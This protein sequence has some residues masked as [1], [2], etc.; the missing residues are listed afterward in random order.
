MKKIIS[1][2]TADIT[3]S[4]IKNGQK[5]D[6]CS[7]P[8][9]QIEDSNGILVE[10]YNSSQIT[11]TGI[12]EYK[13]S[14]DTSNATDPMSI[15]NELVGI[16]DGSTVKFTSDNFPVD[17]YSLFVNDSYVSESE[18]Q[19]NS[20]TGELWFNTAPQN[21]FSIRLNYNVPS[22]NQNLSEGL[23]SDKW[24]VIFNENDLPEKISQQFEIVADDW[25]NYD[26][27]DNLDI[28][29]NIRTKVIPKN[30]INRMLFNISVTS[31]EV[32]NEI[33]FQSGTISIY[34]IR[35]NVFVEDANI[36]I[37]GNDIYYNF[38]AKY[39]VGKYYAVIKLSFVDEI[40]ASQKLWF[41]I[42]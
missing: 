23:Y 29:Y 6:P 36:E 10:L 4:I 3:I 9:V 21:G 35:D 11:K 27:L 42:V 37:N 13:V 22:V 25:N 38:D 31:E 15:T 18:Y 5:T 41:N 1:G 14:F 7:I 16:G 28:V 19:I 39:S 30:S 2:E 26:F 40:L 32:D 24:T 12:G 17:N 34:D 33:I 20:Y 8:F